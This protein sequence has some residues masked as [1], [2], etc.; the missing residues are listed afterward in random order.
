MLLGRAV[1]EAPLPDG[2]AKLAFERATASLAEP[3]PALEG[4]AKQQLKEW[5]ERRSTIAREVGDALRAQPDGERKTLFTAVVG[6][7]TFDDFAS[8][9]LAMPVP[10]EFANSELAKD[11]EA[12][13]RDALESIAMPVVSA[14]KQHLQLCVELAPTAAAPLRAWETYCTERVAALTALEAKVAA[15]PR[16]KR[17]SPRPAV[18]KDCGGSET[19]RAEPAAP[20]PDLRVKPR[21]A[22]IFKNQTMPPA[23]RKRFL[24]EVGKRVAAETKLA[25]VADKDVAAGEAL[26]AQ[27]KLTAK[28]PVCGQAPRLTQV[29]G[30]KYR[31]LITAYVDTDCPDNRGDHKLPCTLTVRFSRAGADNDDGVP[32]QLYAELDAAKVT[33]EALLDAAPKL[34]TQEPFASVYGGLL[35]SEGSRSFAIHGYGDDDPW[36]RIGDT[37]YGDVANRIEAC[38]DDEASF[39]VV[40]AISPKGK[41]TSAALTPVTA[42]K[43]GTNVATCVQKALEQTPWPCTRDGK[44]AQVELR[45]CVAPAP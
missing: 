9:L 42:A 40:L 21:V 14:A 10:P 12:A 15:R 45:M 39:D 33:D 31:H 18:M 30:T 43:P 8:D 2:P 22:L 11:V 34:K 19:I 4:D 3:P 5:V 24:A 26:V 36:L 28:G 7:V 1:A 38:V 32:E 27:K 6:G 25:V 13:Y 29:L 44:P 16:P 23:T 35:G 37:M 17:P 20:P 41:T